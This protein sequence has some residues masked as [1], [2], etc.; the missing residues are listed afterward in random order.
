MDELNLS[1]ELQRLQH[2]LA[3]RIR[4]GPSAALRA[5]VIG[6]VR[7]EFGRQRR[8]AGWAF[9]VAAAAAALVW[10]NLS[11]AATLATDY[12][13][14]PGEESATVEA[15]AS[16]IGEL[17]PEVSR[18]EAVR[19]AVLLESGS[20]LACCPRPEIASHVVTPLDRLDQVLP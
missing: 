9:A 10:I 1:P 4:Q 17:L 14:A 2:D 6:G 3:E 7:G 13:L 16:Q 19:Q 12:R 5:R 11:L 20:K 18:R 15:L 8:R